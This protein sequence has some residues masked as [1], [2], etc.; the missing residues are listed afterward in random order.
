VTRRYSRK[1]VRW[2]RNRFILPSKRQVPPVY[3]VDGTDPSHWSEKVKEPAINIIQ[4]MMNGDQPTCETA[5][6]STS[7]EFSEIDTN[8]KTRYECDVCGRVVIGQL[9]WLAHLKGAKHR[10]MLKRK[11]QASIDS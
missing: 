1:Q 3:T 6:F 7:A 4:A 2:I 8:D 11:H 5:K 10:K 9:Q